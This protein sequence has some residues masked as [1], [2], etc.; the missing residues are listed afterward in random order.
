MS[1]NAKSFDPDMDTVRRVLKMRTLGLSNKEI[2][3]M[4]GLRD[5]EIKA[6]LL[7]TGWNKLKIGSPEFEE[8]DW[9]ELVSYAKECLSQRKE[10]KNAGN[11]ASKNRNTERSET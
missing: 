2:S 10:K 1:K 7:G 8:E 6:I 11:S 9:E 5:C 4:S 3:N